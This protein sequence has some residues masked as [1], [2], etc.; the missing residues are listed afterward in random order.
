LLNGTL[1]ARHGTDP[2]DA[3]QLFGQPGE[4]SRGILR[5][6]AVANRVDREQ[7]EIGEFEAGVQTG[8]LPESGRNVPGDHQQRQ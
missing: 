2:V 8:L 1:S 5:G 7:I 6:V 4:L 3:R